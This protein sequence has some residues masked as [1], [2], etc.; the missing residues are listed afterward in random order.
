MIRIVDLFKKTGG[1]G[2]KKPDDQPA[3]PGAAPPPAGES[4]PSV[5]GLTADELNKTFDA[6]AGAAGFFVGQQELGPEA[7]PQEAS[8]ITALETLVQ[9]QTAGNPELAAVLEQRQDAAAYLRAFKKV[10]RAVRIGLDA[11]YQPRQLNQIALLA[12]LRG[13]ED[14]RPG[15]AGALAVLAGQRIRLDNE[16]FNNIITL[17]DIYEHLVPPGT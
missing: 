11:N 3:Q 13:L 6:L 1:E 5:T 2:G 17:S 8:L 9:Q 10:N 7:A 4:K 12:L 14:G 16:K 15:R